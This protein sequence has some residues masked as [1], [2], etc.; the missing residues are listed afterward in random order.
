MGATSAI[1]TEVARAYAE[2]GARLFLTGRNRERL[3]AVA[4]DIGV[5]G[6]SV[7]IAELDVLDIGSHAAVIEQAFA[8]GG[9]DA[10][11]VAH[12]TLPDQAACRQSPAETVR[13]LEVNFTATVALLTLLANRFEAQHRGTI[14]V[15]TSVAGDRGRQSNYVYGAAKGGLAVFLQGLRNRLH[16]AGVSVV[17]LKPGFVDSPMT[18]GLPRNRLYTT[19]R[20]AG[21]SIHRAIEGR[22]DVAYIPWFWR[23]VMVLIRSLPE[24]VFKRLRL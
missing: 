24:S 12:G 13:A 11:L 18:A 8:S 4:D 10:V 3:A 2:R 14:A 7:E 16:H 23:P 9:L 19:A 20:R 15:I 21:R 17:T 1:A 5:R 6:G 22:R